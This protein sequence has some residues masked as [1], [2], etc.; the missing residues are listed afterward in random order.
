[1]NWFQRGDFVAARAYAEQTLELYNL[2]PVSPA[3]GAHTDILALTYLFKT[4]SQ[5]G[6]LDATPFHGK[7]QARLNQFP[8]C[9]FQLPSQTRYCAFRFFFD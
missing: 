7:K 9:L 6:Y 1:M 5:L 8:K 2:A 3:W 4:P